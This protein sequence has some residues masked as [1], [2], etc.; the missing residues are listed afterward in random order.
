MFKNIEKCKKCDLCKNQIPLLD[1]AKNCD[2]MWVGLS[3]KKVDD[4]KKDTP[5]SENTNSGAVIAEI[6]SRCEGILTYK[7]NL[8]KC[9]P[10][11]EANKLRYPKKDEIDICFENLIKEI[12]TLKPKIVFL[13]GTEVTKSVKREFKLKFIDCENDSL[14]LAEYK[15]IDFV[16][17][18]HPSYVSSYRKK[19]KDKYIEQI[20]EYINNKFQSLEK[21]CYEA[22]PV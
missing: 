7:T 11:D 22:I 17:V 1:K 9:L 10:L 4:V 12:T 5:L 6:E 20:S 16:S 14:K 21:N 18:Y 19:Y 15:G 2:V 13:L 8:V 3:A